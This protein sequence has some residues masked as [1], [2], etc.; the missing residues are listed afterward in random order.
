MTETRELTIVIDSD[1]DD[2]LTE[3]ATATGRDK[4][5]IARD[6]L[7]EWREDREDVRGAEEIIRQGNPTILLGE[8]GRR[9][10]LEG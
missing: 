10:S 3:L 4:L 7:T 6:A 9:L 1:L 8:A 2:E 5:A